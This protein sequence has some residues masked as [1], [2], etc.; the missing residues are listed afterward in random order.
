MK[1]IRYE[2]HKRYIS[3]IIK[4]RRKRVTTILLMLLFYLIIF[5]V[6][7]WIFG[8]FYRR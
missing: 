6:L 3:E 5:L 7:C 8:V 2:R 4:K 1:F